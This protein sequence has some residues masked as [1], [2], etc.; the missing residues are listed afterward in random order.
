MCGEY[1]N[2]LGHCFPKLK[3]VELLEIGQ[4]TVVDK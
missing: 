2:Y 4:C 1:V 3:Y